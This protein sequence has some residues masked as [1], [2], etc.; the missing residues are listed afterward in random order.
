MVDTISAMVIG[1]FVEAPAV[2]TVA[3]VNPAST[4]VATVV[5]ASM[6]R[7][8]FLILTSFTDASAPNRIPGAG[9]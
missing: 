5:A 9:L 7:I 2:S 6:P 4:T 8:G 3:V 1:A